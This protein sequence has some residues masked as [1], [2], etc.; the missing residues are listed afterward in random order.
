MAEQVNAVSCST[1][2]A[3]YTFTGNY[4]SMTGLKSA[5]RYRLRGGTLSI[6]ESDSE[7][8]PPYRW[9]LTIDDLGNQLDP[10]ATSRIAIRVVGED[11]VTGLPNVE[12]LSPDVPREVYDLQGR[13]MNTR[14]TLKSGI[15]I[16]NN[17]KCV[18]K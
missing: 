13:K 16:I 9:Y 8:L 14:S 10:V 15:Y 1:L 7:I 11:E 12:G 6:P 2:E 17:K 18:V 4:S 5:N 3:R